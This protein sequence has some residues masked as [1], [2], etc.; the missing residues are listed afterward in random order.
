MRGDERGEKKTS[1]RERERRRRRGNNRRREVH[2]GERAIERAKHYTM[3]GRR[4]RRESE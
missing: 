3:S 2:D 1:E 4:R